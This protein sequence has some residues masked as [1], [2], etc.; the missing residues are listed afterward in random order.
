MGSLFGDEPVAGGAPYCAS[1][2]AIHTLTRVLA[3]ELGHAGITCNT[4][5]PGFILTPMHAEE[6]EFQAWKRGITSE[7]RYAELREEVPCN[8]TELPM[9]LLRTVLLAPPVKQSI[10]IRPRIAT[11]TPLESM[12]EQVP[13]ELWG[14]AKAFLQIR[15]PALRFAW[16]NGS[17]QFGGKIDLERLLEKMALT[18]R[19]G[20][21][22]LAV[23]LGL[24]RLPLPGGLPASGGLGVA[25]LELAYR[26]RL[27]IDYRP[28]REDLSKRVPIRLGI[29]S[30]GNSVSDGIQVL[31]GAMLAIDE[32]NHQG[33]IS[34][35]AIEAVTVEVNMFNGESISEGLGKLFEADV[36]AI[37]TSYASAEHPETFDLIAS[38][39]KPFLHTATFEADVQ[40][41]EREPWK[42]GMIFQTCAS[43]NHY[44]PGMLRL[45]GQ[46]EHAQTWTPH[47]RN[48]VP[49]E[50]PM[51]S[52][53][54][55]RGAI[56]ARGA[57][58]HKAG[59]S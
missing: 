14:Y 36:D 26:R 19:G 24:L 10:R 48:I 13:T 37:V 35:R 30:P 27:G 54:L 39:G 44:A 4:V 56:N 1:K 6:V 58:G 20:L 9:T 59:I 7:Q 41:A 46:L 47:T 18:S 43:E 32:I 45:L 29:L 50:L 17:P 57:A 16:R 21:A 31:G 33:G 22:A 25:E 8:V 40:R 49:L 52:M 51:A 15:R 11:E 2:G 23:D 42:Y 28:I 5:A 53:H 3:I 12:P 55:T 38:Y 34:G